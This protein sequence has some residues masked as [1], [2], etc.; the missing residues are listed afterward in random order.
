MVPLHWLIQAS[1]PALH[2]SSACLRF[3]GN[4]SHGNEMG[5]RVMESEQIAQMRSEKYNATVHG[6]N[7]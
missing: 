4:P 1:A 7:K 5:H 3:S 2:R 6:L